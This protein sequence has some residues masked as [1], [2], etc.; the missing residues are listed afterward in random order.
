MWCIRR[1]FNR[2]QTFGEHLADLR[3]RARKSQNEVAML[4]GIAEWLIDRYEKDE[5]IP[6]RQDLHKIARAIN[7]DPYWLLRWRD[8]NEQY[9]NNIP[10]IILESINAYVMTGRP[11]GGFLYAVLTNNLKESFQRADEH[12]ELAMKWI[13]RYLY[14]RVPGSCWGTKERVADWIEKGGATGNEKFYDINFVDPI[15]DCNARYI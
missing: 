4:T 11:V 10:P 13:V 6:K 15:W 12:C 9:A 7:A 1:G 5:Q 2:D 8:S 3:N 14:N